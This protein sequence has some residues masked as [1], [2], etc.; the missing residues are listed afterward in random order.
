MNVPIVVNASNIRPV[1]KP[2]AWIGYDRILL[3]DV[4]RLGLHRY[5]IVRKNDPPDVAIYVEQASK[6]A[7]YCESWLIH[8]DDDYWMLWIVW[9]ERKE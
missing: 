9:K 7:R 6:K 2:L 3:D 4:S 1:D 5:V 8:R